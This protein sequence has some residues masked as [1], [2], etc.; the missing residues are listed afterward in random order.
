[1]TNDVF[2]R[3]ALSQLK[4]DYSK[5]EQHATELKQDNVELRN[6]LLAKEQRTAEL[7]RKNETQVKGAGM[8]QALTCEVE[9]V[10]D[11]L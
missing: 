7:Q 8:Y 2:Y 9:A 1:M 5:L 10:Q 4:R 11:H 3:E 6:A